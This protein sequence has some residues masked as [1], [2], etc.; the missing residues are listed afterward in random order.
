MLERK[1]ALKKARE[2]FAALLEETPEL[3]AAT[4]FSQ[5]ERLLE[6]D[7]RWKVIPAIAALTACTLPFCSS[8]LLL[9][10]SLQAEGLLELD[11]RWKVFPAT[12]TLAACILALCIS[13]VYP[14][15]RSL[16]IGGKY[17]ASDG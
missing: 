14:A 8:V 15:G 1:L 2:D 12:A 3:K 16:Q 9:C 11:P 13:V 17:I 4:R 7:P 5:A 6:L 10:R